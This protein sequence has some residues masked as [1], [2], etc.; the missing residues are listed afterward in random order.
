MDGTDAVAAYDAAETV[1]RARKG[2]GPTDQAVTMRTAT[3]SDPNYV[4]REMFEE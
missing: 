2:E 3:P 1:T 4:P